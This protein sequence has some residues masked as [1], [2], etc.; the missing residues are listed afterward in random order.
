M[1]ID[2]RTDSTLKRKVGGKWEIS[3]VWAEA[4]SPK[5]WLERSRN[6]KLFM[7]KMSQPSTAVALSY[8]YPKPIEEKRAEK[9]GQYSE[10]ELAASSVGCACFATELSEWDAVCLTN[11]VHL[12]R[13]AVERV[14]RKDT[15]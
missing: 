1:S 13:S 11:C 3:T 10:A 4:L 7:G 8:A 12:R 5:R 2:S 15:S 9:R 14:R 6:G